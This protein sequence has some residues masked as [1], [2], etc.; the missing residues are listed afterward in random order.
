MN[1][2]SFTFLQTWNA[3][4][5]LASAFA[6]RAF[7]LFM[8]NLSLF[9]LKILFLYIDF[10]GTTLIRRFNKCLVKI[11]DHFRL[12]FWALCILIIWLVLEIFLIG[13][14]CYKA[15]LFIWLSFIDK[16]SYHVSAW[17]IFGLVENVPNDLLHLFS[18]YSLVQLLIFASLNMPLFITVYFSQVYPIHQVLRS[19]TFEVNSDVVRVETVK[20][21]LTFLLLMLHYFC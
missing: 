17:W 21:F 4:R 15:I 7:F 11:V 19:V 5:N 1:L 18:V 13:I 20:N 16:V 2:W 9:V 6:A 10:L 12:H 3:Y 8:N 14:A